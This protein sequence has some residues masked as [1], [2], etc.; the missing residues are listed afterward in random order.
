MIASVPDLCIIFT[1]KI[2]FGPDSGG[3]M[4]KPQHSRSHPKV[5]I[6]QRSGTEAIRNKIQPS[7]PK[8]EITK[9]TNI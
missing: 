7:K 2:I 4:C 6:I 5:K 8:R 1:F 9:I 3:P